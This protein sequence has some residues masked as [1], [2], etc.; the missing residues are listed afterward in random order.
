MHAVVGFAWKSNP[1]TKSYRQER[2]ELHR[3]PGRLAV[4]FLSSVRR[5]A[6]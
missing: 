5:K 3:T 6:F 1:W 4:R 2:L